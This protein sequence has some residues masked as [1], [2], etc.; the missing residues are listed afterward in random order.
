MKIDVFGV[1]MRVVI[2]PRIPPDVAYVVCPALLDALV[3]DEDLTAVEVDFQPTAHCTIS[4][5]PN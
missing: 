2:D 5:V 4:E 1:P 3:W